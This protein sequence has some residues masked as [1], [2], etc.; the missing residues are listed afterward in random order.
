M[1][2]GFR[3][4]RAHWLG[5]LIIAGVVALAAVPYAAASTPQPD[6]GIRP[7]EEGQVP[8]PGG[9]FNYSL[10]AGSHVEDAVVAENLTGRPL[11]IQVYSADLIPLEGGGFG[12]GQPGQ[13]EQGAGA[14][15]TVA[16]SN[17]TLAPHQQQN[18]AFQ[19]TV[20]KDAFSGDYGGAVVLQEA[21]TTDQGIA[22]EVRAALQIRIHVIGALP[23]LAASVGPVRWHRSGK[24]IDFSAAVTNTG[25]ESFQFT[26]NVV[27]H[28]GRSQFV[29]M[30]PAGDY[31]FPGQSVTLTGR[32]DH[33]PV[34]GSAAARVSVMATTAQGSTK[35]FSDSTVKL[36][37][38]PWWLV[39]MAIVA[40]LLL[41]LAVIIAWRQRKQW[42]ERFTAARAR[43]REVRQ[44]KRHLA[45]EVQ[46][47]EDVYSDS[48][49]LDTNS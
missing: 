5:S 14:W 17:I 32:W 7:A 46:L 10:E 11:S 3:P 33:P 22:V 13:Q 24:S 26:G 39:L 35:S 34:W 20:P 36:H 30:S 16:E 19:V 4:R 1:T 25:N 18:V 8:L 41:L 29:R 45:G 49:P 31:L 28:K 37:F 23:H 21:S 48:A 6:F 2:A 47:A 40:L 38:F 27:V 44:F 42:R 9:H 15:V 12:V 43:R